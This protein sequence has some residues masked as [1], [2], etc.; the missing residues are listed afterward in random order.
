MNFWRRLFFRGEG[1]KLAN[2]QAG[3]SRLVLP[4][5]GIVSAILTR[6]LAGSRSDLSDDTLTQV[7]QALAAQLTT[8]ALTS[9]ASWPDD[10]GAVVPAV[11]V[12]PRSLEYDMEADHGRLLGL[13]LMFFAARV[14]DGMAAGMR[15]LSSYLDDQATGSIKNLIDSDPTLGG[16]CQCCRIL[17]WEEI[18]LDYILVPG[19]PQYIGAVGTVEVAT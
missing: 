19:G 4:H 6:A 10:L 7:L 15:I 18:R 5:Q 16:K 1:A 11:A 2:P 13:S 8:G 17:G 14:T 12:L 3:G 9:Y